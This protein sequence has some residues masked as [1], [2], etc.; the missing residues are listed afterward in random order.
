MNRLAC[1]RLTERCATILISVR[2][3]VADAGDQVGEELNEPIVRLVECVLLY[4]FSFHHSLFRFLIF[5]GE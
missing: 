4:F 2:E 1:L 5:L 3:E